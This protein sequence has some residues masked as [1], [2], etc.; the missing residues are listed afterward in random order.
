MTVTQTAPPLPA[1]VQVL[2]MWQGSLVERMLRVAAE[3]DIWS[4]LQDGPR[5]TAELAAAT[6]THEDS[7]GRLLRALAGLGLLG[8]DAQGWALTPLGAA[9]GDLGVPLR[10]FEP[11]IAALGSTVETGRPAM[12]TVH[13]CTAF[14]YL[15]QHPDEAAEFDALMTLI[16]SGE[17][18]AVADAYDFAGA[19]RV[20]DV[21]GGTGTLLA[22][23]LRRNPKLDGVLFDVPETAARAAS[24]LGAYAG[25]C[26]TVAGDFFQAVPAGADV[27]LLSHV[28]HDWSAPQALAILARVREGIAHDGKLVV[29]E[30]VMPSDDTPHPARMVDMTMLMITD[31]GRERTE[32]EY[33]DLLARA[34]FRLERVI[35]TRSSVSVLEAVPC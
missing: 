1:P 13:G 18:E 8:S 12:V 29:V 15:A 31:G 16:N 32:D 27:Y 22:E 23:V 3:H 26:E 2:R 6:G 21:G 10:W 35:P 11:V 5:T 33:A 14:E 28:L 19:R 24:E 4:R 7:L 25:R 17:P 30:N 34:G 20:V 9:A